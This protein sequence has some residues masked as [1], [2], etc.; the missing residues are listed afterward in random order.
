[1]EISEPGRHIS[2]YRGFLIV[3]DQNAEIGRVALD[4]VTAVMATTSAFTASG[5]VLAELAERAIPF[6]LCGK[7]FA[8]IGLMWPLGGHHAQQRRMEAQIA[9]PKPLCK[10]LWQQVVA[11]K[12]RGQGHTLAA[13]GHPAGA[14]VRLASQVKSGDPDNLEALAARR[15]WPLLFGSQFRRDPDGGGANGLLNYGYAV[16]R[17]ATARALAAAGL[18]PG[19]GIFHRHPN[20]PMPLADDFMEPFRPFVDLAVATLSAKYGEIVNADAKHRLVAVLQ[21]NLPTTAGTSPLNTCLVRLGASLAGC[22]L[23][24]TVELDLP[25]YKAPDAENPKDDDS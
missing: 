23:N 11:A 3:A 10:R 16:L 18:H 4:D 19:I 9:A 1:M 20:N 17:S 14:F 12:I 24:G 2:L 7:N 8:P 25:L 22:F 6:V 21:T 13:L 5:V 15:Y